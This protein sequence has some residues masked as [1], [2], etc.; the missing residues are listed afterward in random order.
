MDDI[1]IAPFHCCSFL[2]TYTRP[3]MLVKSLVAITAVA[4][5]VGAVPQ[6]EK[7]FE[8]LPVRLIQLSQKPS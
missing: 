3:P 8:P 6:P 4:V 5:V 7:R 2:V 1:P